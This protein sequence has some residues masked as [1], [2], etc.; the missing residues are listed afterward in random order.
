M[1]NVLITGAGKGL[2]FEL[3][4]QYAAEGWHVFTSVLDANEQERVRALGEH[5]RTFVADTT[6]R[7]TLARM[8]AD[9]QGTPIDVLICNAGIY[10]PVG[11]AFG[12]TDYAAWEQ[13]LRVNVL[14]ST[15]TIE[16]L[17]ANV[18][19]SSRKLIVVMSSRLGSIAWN[20]GSDPIYRSSKA[21]L[22]QVV[23]TLSVDLVG[24]GVTIVAVSP[25]W[26]RTDM[27][28]PDA[29]LSP[30]VS[31]NGVRKVIAGL[32]SK[33]T[34]KYLAFDGTENAW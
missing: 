26:V 12:E 11:Q 18:E 29:P 31:I 30:E 8:A 21:A 16:A 9:L 25:G 3:A 15:A 4:R 27:G 14:G 23:K 19:A 32:T 5:V 33:D 1:P 22:N 34:G 24:R 10:G 13:V 7:A 6:K 28:G 2:G 17:I 20:D